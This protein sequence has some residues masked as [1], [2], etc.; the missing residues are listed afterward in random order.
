[1]QQT[2]EYNK[3]RSRLTD[4]QNKLVV[5]NEKTEPG[6]QATQGW[7]HGRYQLLGVRDGDAL[8]TQAIVNPKV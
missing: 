2:S 3:K 6:R 1:M 4:I 5:T 7:G 8:V